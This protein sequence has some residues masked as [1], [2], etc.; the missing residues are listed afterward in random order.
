MAP[1]VGFHE[2]CQKRS[3]CYP[4]PFVRCFYRVSDWQYTG[5]RFSQPISVAACAFVAIF[6]TVALCFF[7]LCHGFQRPP[8]GQSPQR[9]QRLASLFLFSYRNFRRRFRNAQFNNYR[10]VK[11]PR[12]RRMGFTSLFLRSFSMRPRCLPAYT[13]EGSLRIFQGR[14]F[15]FL[16]Q[17]G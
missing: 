4:C 12:L 11:R 13:P 9:T 14:T 17:S 8:F 3:A 5:S 7:T 1:P 16:C 15:Y 2:S 6:V 10:R